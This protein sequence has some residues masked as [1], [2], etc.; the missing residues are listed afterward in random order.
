M[1]ETT[2]KP[3]SQ[4]PS[5]YVEWHWWADAQ[6]KAGLKQSQCPRC[7]LWIYPQ[8]KINHEKCDIIPVKE[9]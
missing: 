3:G 6:E 2:Y 7:G 8:E 4:P 9:K 1:S 5:S